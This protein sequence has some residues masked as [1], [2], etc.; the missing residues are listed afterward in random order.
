MEEAGSGERREN[1]RRIRLFRGEILQETER[2]FHGSP[3]VVS[4]ESAEGPHVTFL[5]A[6]RLETRRAGCGG[7]G[8]R[9]Q[10]QPARHPVGDLILNSEEVG[11]R[12][13]D[14]VHGDLPLLPGV[15]DR[16]GDADA[17]AR[18]LKGTGDDDV[19]ADARRDAIGVV[20]LFGGA[21]RR[22]RGHDLHSC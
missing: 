21:G 9:V 20:F 19:G 11:D 5:L 4:L 7:A 8:A 15:Q 16:E 14:L 1:E 13:G 12:T 2:F 3:L 22:R 10:I 6:R 17:V 18:A